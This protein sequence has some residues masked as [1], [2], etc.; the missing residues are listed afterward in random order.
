MNATAEDCCPVVD[1][2]AQVDTQKVNPNDSFSYARLTDL[3]LH[4]QHRIYR[5][6]AADSAG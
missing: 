1:T 3:H 5:I 2:V 4:K 6:E